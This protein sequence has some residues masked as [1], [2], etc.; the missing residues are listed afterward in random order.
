MNTGGRKRNDVKLEDDEAERS[1]EEAVED[2]KFVM[3]EED[4]GE[5]DEEEGEDLMENM[6]RDYKN[7]GEI[8]QYDKE[9]LDDQEYSDISA[10][11][12]RRADRIV[13]GR[14]RDNL[15]FNKRMPAAF[16]D[17]NSVISNELDADR[18]IRNRRYDNNES[19]V[20]MDEEYDMDE[21]DDERF[22]DLEEMRG[23][24]G[25]LI[26][27]PK[28]VRFIKKTFKRFIM[29]Y[30]DENGELLY[31]K[32]I[33]EMCSTNGQSLEVVYMHI[34]NNIPTIAYWIFESPA[35]ILPH[36]NSTA[37]D[38][39]CRFFPG[40]QEIRPEIYVRIRSF[41]LEE[42]IRDLRTF[43]LHTLIKIVGVITRRYPVYSQ[44]KKVYY[45]CGRCGVKMGPIYQNDTQEVKLSNCSVCGCS[46]PFSIDSEKTVYRN[47]QK[48][49]V[50]ESPG[51]VLPGRVPR[52]K[53]V[54]LFAD[55]IDCAR[56]GEEI[57]VVG[58]YTSKFDY[59][60]NVK[61]G[62]PVFHTLIEANCIRKI[63]DIQVSDISAHDKEEI[64]R[65]SRKPDISRILINSIAPS[66]HGHFNIKT[67]LT[68]AMFGGEP[69]N[70][71]GSHRIRG[72]INVLL[73][74]DPGLAK[75]QFLKYVEKTFHRTVYTTGKGA[76]A[77]GLTASVR[78]DPGTREWVLE[79]GAMVLADQGVCLIDEFDK[80][81]EMDRTS[82]H[83]AMEQQSISISKA[84]IVASLQAR[85]SVIAAAN[86][87]K[88]RYD[89]QLS[90]SDNVNLSEPILSRFDILCVLRDDQDVTKD[91]DLATFIINSHIKN[92]PNYEEA[93][94]K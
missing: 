67:A 50:Q 33:R 82:I 63:S 39:A 85:C 54:I 36:L 27:E 32:R 7:L 6:E 78:M 65:L 45:I 91:N 20:M 92:H 30:K 68:L 25:S 38:I 11:K 22:G 28:T 5:G 41:P 37:F 75:S 16:M 59:G 35:I 46:G 69:Q 53:D 19:E 74:G 2:R 15:A 24:L 81:S 55:N 66:I 71:N 76:S 84:G 58:I 72:D 90:F 34:T 13:D 60:M 21:E 12:R 43:H 77:V 44:L 29:G 47:Y 57:E 80:M 49:T 9:E 61:H 31:Q 10:E 52:Y 23:K 83:E 26:T 73:L 42:K 70:V 8:D 48:I 88:G 14:H 89:M 94:N 1:E 3:D 64:M 17:D 79:G 86:P 40:Y 87:I 62:F 4:F 51:T 93:E 18:E 56:P